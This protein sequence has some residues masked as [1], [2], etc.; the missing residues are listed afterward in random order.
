MTERGSGEKQGERVNKA[1]GGGGR[2]RGEREERRQGF[3]PGSTHQHGLWRKQQSNEIL[4]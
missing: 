1:R 2:D 4:K 3:S